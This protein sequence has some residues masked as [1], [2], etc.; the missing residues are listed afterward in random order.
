MVCLH[1]ELAP[2]ID[3]ATA[4]ISCVLLPLLN[5]QQPE[6]LSCQSTLMHLQTLASPLSGILGDRFDRILVLSSGA[7][8]WGIMTSAMALTVTLR[9]VGASNS[10]ITMLRCEVECSAAVTAGTFHLPPGV[11][12]VTTP[13][14]HLMPVLS[15][16]GAAG[17]GFCWVQWSGP[18]PAGAMLSESYS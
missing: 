11:C 14:P 9:Q 2:A 12:L 5:T 3:S 7:F 16:C 8:I 13:L 10:E 4:S 6:L 15:L 18:G 17:N 1:G